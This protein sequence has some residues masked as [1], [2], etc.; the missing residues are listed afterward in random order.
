MFQELIVKLDPGL[1]VEEARTTADA[2]SMIRGV[3]M[4]GDA[5]WHN[6]AVSWLMDAVRPYLR[7]TKPGSKDYE[8]LREKMHEGVQ[9]IAE[10]ERKRLT[11]TKCVMKGEVGSGDEFCL[12]H[13]CGPTAQCGHPNC[14]HCQKRQRKEPHDHHP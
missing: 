4:V 13:E 11:R 8:K 10:A 5:D 7:A 1:S 2:I 9:R 14:P 3:G 6:L 12:T